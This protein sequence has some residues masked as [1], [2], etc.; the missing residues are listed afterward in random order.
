MR[1]ILKEVK[2]D[3]KALLFVVV[4][5]LIAGKDLLQPG[6]FNMHDDLQMMR[7]FSLEAC[8]K[9]LQIPCRWT[10]YMGYGFGFPLFNYYPQLPYLFGEVF[11]LI[12][13]SFVDTIKAT[14]LLSFVTSGLAM[15]VLAKEFW[16]KLGGI[17]SAA[18]YIWAPYHSVDVF[19]RGAMNEAWA[20]VWFP[21]ILWSGYK[22]ITKA[23]FRHIVV[24]SL[25]WFGLLNSHNLMALI[26]VPFFGAWALLWL[27]REKSWFTVPQLVISGIWAL[28]LSAFFTIPVTLEKNLVHVESMVVG[29][30]E[31]IVHF[32][33]I[34]QLLISRFWGYGPSTWLT[35]DKMSFQIGYLHWILPLVLLAF[36]IYRF[37]KKRK[38]DDVILA[39][40]FFVL[41][42]WFA[43]FMTQ[44]RSTPLWVRLDP[45][46][47]YVQF[48]WRFL[49]LVI[50]AFSTSAGAVIVLIDRPGKR[51]ILKFFSVL[52]LVV[53]LYALNVGY[54]HP[55]KIGPLTDEEKF[56]GKAWDLQQTAG[57]YDYLPVGAKTA[58]KAPQKEVAEIV[59]G[60]ASLSNE[61]QGTNWASFDATVM[62]E[63]ATIQINIFSFP[64]WQVYM[65]GK[66]VDTFIGDDEWGRMRLEVPSGEHK[67]T[68]KFKDTPIRKVANFI[69][70]SSWMALLA[71]PFWRKMVS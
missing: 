70:L 26:F 9:D 58:P 53:G 42:G 69:S 55:E 66:K 34:N 63:I 38:I 23:Q 27:V 47:R 10:P 61:H 50:L 45:L 41:A 56:S 54:F 6:Y 37:Y 24:L 64:N 16:G 12:G 5:A 20:L 21:I 35:D 14:M 60:N 59:K 57:I 19:V 4:I 18:F 30:Y 15:Y 48:P 25:A 17:L 71:V 22:I 1:R 2:K 52:I 8:F 28:G 65:D 44:S 31:Y 40:S 51:N 67:V 32:T 39:T 36:A 13:F 7:Q 33:S 3:W 11:R 29:Y 43:A 46:L 62:D 68:A 49:A